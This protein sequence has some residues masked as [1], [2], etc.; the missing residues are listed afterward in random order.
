MREGV[1][2]HHTIAS[3]IDHVLRFRGK[4]T[5][6]WA[7]ARKAR[8][9]AVFDY[10]PAGES[11]TG[12]QR[13]RGS[14]DCPTSEAWK[15]WGAGEALELSQDE[16][17]ELLATRTTTRRRHLLD[18]RDAELTGGDL[19]GKKAPDP[20]WMLSMLG[21]LESTAKATAKME[22]DPNTH[23]RKITYSRESGFVGTIAPPRAFLIEIPVF[24]GEP[25]EPLEVRLRADVNS[26]GEATFRLQIHNAVTVL[27]ESFDDLCARVQA[28][29][30]VPL[31][32]GSPEGDQPSPQDD[33]E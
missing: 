11:G 3:F 33:G 7:D 2:R 29:T 31:F 20:A 19:N 6:I 8:L 18:S 1:A 9:Q 30:D 24:E 21:S 16:L 12:W 14:A 17:A 23:Q 22:R 26:S 28:K 15:A 4:N 25:D 27:R 13:H 5:A 10:H 32:V